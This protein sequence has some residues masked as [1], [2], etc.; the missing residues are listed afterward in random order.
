[1]S[2]SPCAPETTANMINNMLNGWTN[3]LK[4]T[5]YQA[6]GFPVTIMLHP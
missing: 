2:I 4:N 5:L 1:V 6:N 3:V